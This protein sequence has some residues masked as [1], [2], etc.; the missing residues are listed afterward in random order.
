[1]GVPNQVKASHTVNGIQR[2]VQAKL[3]APHDS[4]SESEK[5][6]SISFTPSAILSITRLACATDSN[7]N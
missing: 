4:Q 7:G 5:K 3:P 1:M 6:R 2:T